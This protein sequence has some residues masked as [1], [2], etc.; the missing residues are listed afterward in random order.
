[1]GT[2]KHNGNHLNTLLEKYDMKATLFLITGWWDV[3]NYMSPNLDIQSHTYDMH[4]KGSC[5]Q[6][7]LV[8]ADYETAKKD[9]EK[10]LGVI[11]RKESFC[12]PFY[13]YDD[14][15]IQAVKEL[16][17]RVAFGG[18]NQ[19]ATLSSNRYVIPRYPIYNDHGVDYIKRIVN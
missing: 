2:G 1:M 14:E 17:F 3:A 12:Y 7:Q 15:A 5:G 13:Q 19:K 16:G 10:S 9:L 8:C 4:N 6:G 18:G 11:G